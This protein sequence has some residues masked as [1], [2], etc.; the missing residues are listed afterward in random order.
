MVYKALLVL[1]PKIRRLLRRIY[2]HWKAKHTAAAIQIQS[3]CR[4]YLAR[5]KVY[6]LRGPAYLR[7]VFFPAIVDVQRV[8]RGYRAR[9][10][11]TQGLDAFLRERVD[12]PAAI[13]CQRVFRGHV[14]SFARTCMAIV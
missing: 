1:Q 4:I 7:D 5:I 12:H 8:Y 2:R 13:E 6:K 10:R 11:F 9:V 14:V 3:I